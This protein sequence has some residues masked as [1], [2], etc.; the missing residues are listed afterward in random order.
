MGN[1]VV[2]Y[3]AKQYVVISKNCIEKLEKRLSSI[4]DN[5]TSKEVKQAIKDT[6]HTLQLERKDSYTFSQCLYEAM[7][8]TDSIIVADMHT[9]NLVSKMEYCLRKE[10]TSVFHAIEATKKLLT[11]LETARDEYMKGIQI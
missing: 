3:S 10:E 8:D 6:I 9:E 1:K 5:A 2:K 7:P 4:E 11:Y